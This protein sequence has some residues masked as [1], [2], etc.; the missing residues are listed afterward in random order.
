MFFNNIVNNTFMITV[1]RLCVY[2]TDLKTGHMLNMCTLSVHILI[3]IAAA[4][5][6]SVLYKYI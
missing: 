4:E 1:K 6:L 5:R 2:I 3:A